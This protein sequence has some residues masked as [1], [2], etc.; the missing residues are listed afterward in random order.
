ME[1][2]P[3]C[4]DRVLHAPKECTI[5]DEYA[6]Q[7]QA[8][9]KAAGVN[10]TGQSLPGLKPCPSDAARG[11]GGAHVWGGNTPK[12]KANATCK[13]CGGPAFA[14]FSDVECLSFACVPMFW[15]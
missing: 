3:H 4:D 1:R 15:I 7:M 5:C 11:V 9:R 10:F 12:P 6:P 8:D 13:D 14:L 2:F